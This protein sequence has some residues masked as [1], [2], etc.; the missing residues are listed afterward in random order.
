MVPERIDDSSYSPT[1]L[2]AHRPHDGRSGGN[3]PFECGV[4]ILQNQ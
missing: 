2:V 4:W 1:M 3:S